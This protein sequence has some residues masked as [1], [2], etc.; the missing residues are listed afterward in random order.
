MIESLPQR[1]RWNLLD[2]VLSVGTDQVVTQTRFSHAVVEGH[3]PGDP[4]V[5]A[6]LLLEAAAQSLLVLSD[7]LGIEGTP[8]LAGFD[9]A[10][11]LHPVRPEQC[12]QLTTTLRSRLASTLQAEV[13]LT[14]DDTRV[15]SVRVTGTMA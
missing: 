15:A 10:R 7:T 2:Q 5:P 11:F 8:R 12:V 1:G 14:V 6:A 4:V 3:F 13:V 9:R